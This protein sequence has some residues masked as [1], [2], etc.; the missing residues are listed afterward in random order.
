VEGGWAHPHPASRHYTSSAYDE[1]ER[2]FRA[3]TLDFVQVN[4]GSASARP[5][6]VLPLARDL[7]GCP[8]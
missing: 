7:A 3:E 2:V 1:L 8:R 6:A 4:H 5:S